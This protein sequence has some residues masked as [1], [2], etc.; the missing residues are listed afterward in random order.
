MIN[1]VTIWE[2]MHGL[3]EEEWKHKQ[4]KDANNL[5]QFNQKEKK[6]LEAQVEVTKA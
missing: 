4:K 5:E 1:I 3:T 6:L 2:F